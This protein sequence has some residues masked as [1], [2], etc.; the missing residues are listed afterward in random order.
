MNPAGIVGMAC[1]MEL[2][3]S[4]PMGREQVNAKAAA[5][6][7]RLFSALEAALDGVTLNGPPLQL[8]AD[9]S[10]EW[11]RLPGNLNL[12]LAQ[13]EGETWMAAAPE[14]A[15]SSGSACSSTDGLPSH[16]L[17]AMGLTESEARR[18]LRFGIGRGNTEAEIQRASE[19]LVAAYRKVDL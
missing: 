18:S 4:D 12:R 16:V 7:Q 3:L 1:A 13:V 10:G 14:I 19:A 8:A 17:L 15:F 6:R 2:A 5:L 11:K 9:D